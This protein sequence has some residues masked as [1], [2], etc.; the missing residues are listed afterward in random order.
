M[1]KAIE[2]KPTALDV[3]LKKKLDLLRRYWFAY[4]R[5]H[6]A[7]LGEIEENQILLQF[8]ECRKFN[9]WQLNEALYR[10]AESSISAL[11]WLFPDMKY[12]DYPFVH[13]FLRKWRNGNQH[14]ERTDF[15][16]NDGGFQYNNKRHDLPLGY[17]VLP[18]FNLNKE[19]KKV[20]KSQFGSDKIA[21]DATVVELVKNHHIFMVKKFNEY[22]ANLNKELP[23]KYLQSIVQ[24]HMTMYGGVHDEF[25]SEDDF[26]KGEINK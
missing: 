8:H 18:V 9:T 19:L 3:K 24:E 13:K 20:V 12:K 14:D 4:K 5:A 23:K 1:D 15:F 22:E 10:Y 7:L 21:T 25:V 6:H 17:N 11:F 16:L 26:W 2:K